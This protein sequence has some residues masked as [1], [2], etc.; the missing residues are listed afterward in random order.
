MHDADYLRKQFNV[1]YNFKEAFSKV[2]F[3]SNLK[4]YAAKQPIHFY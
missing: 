2:K 1:S 3:M 4:V